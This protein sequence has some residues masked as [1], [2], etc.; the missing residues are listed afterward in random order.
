VKARHLLYGSNMSK[1]SDWL[2]LLSILTAQIDAYLIERRN[3]PPVFNLYALVDAGQIPES[4]RQQIAEV[5]HEKLFSN[6]KEYK[7][8]KYGPYLLPLERDANSKQFPMPE[9]LNTMQYGWTVSW[10]TS[11]LDLKELAAHFAC[12]LEGELEDGRKTLIRYYDPRVLAPFL[13]HIDSQTRSSIVSPIGKWT[14]WDRSLDLQTISGPGKT[15]VSKN[16]CTPINACTR[17]AM[18]LASAP[19]LIM[20]KLLSDSDTREMY[21]WLPHT[22]YRTIFTLATKARQFGLEDIADVYLFVSLAFTVH[23]DFHLKLAVFLEK[24][25]TIVDGTCTFLDLVSEIPDEEWNDVSEAGTDIRN[26]MR[27]IAY[28]K[29]IHTK[30]KGAGNG[31]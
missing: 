22:L 29:L 24:Q 23:P 14:Y 21:P 20:S 13:E 26:N 30:T 7:I 6:T 25:K 31:I 27:Q 4:L 1:Q 11:K 3:D 17:E 19:D 2:G 12:H 16:L 28:Q 8:E 15:S 18:A 5:K 9:L 10:L